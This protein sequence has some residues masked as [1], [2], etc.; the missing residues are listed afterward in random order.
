MSTGEQHNGNNLNLSTE[1]AEQKHDLLN[2][3]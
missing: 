3:L 1:V 2:S